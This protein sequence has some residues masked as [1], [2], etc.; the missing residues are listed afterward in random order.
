VALRTCRVFRSDLQGVE[1]AVE[2]TA[3]TLSQVVAQGLRVF[4]ANEWV[5]EIGNGRTVITVKVKQPEV[6]HKGSGG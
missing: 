4:R 1:H 5:K 6:E 2:V 3:D